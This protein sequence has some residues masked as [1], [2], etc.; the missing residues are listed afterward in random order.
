MAF[1]EQELNLIKNTVGVYAESIAPAA[2]ANQVTYTYEVD[3]NAV[4]IW[5]NRAP[6][7]GRG[8][9]THK[10]VAR[11]R[12]I[13]SRDEWELYWMRADLKWHRYE[14][15]EATPSLEELVQVVK[16][17]QYCCFIL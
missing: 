9:W 7:D 15:A 6:W 4:I 10:G 14:P 8:G 1:S 2:V 11:F 12:Y 5:E 17:D 3:G 16:E 13:R